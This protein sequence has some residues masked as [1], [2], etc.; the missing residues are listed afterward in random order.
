MKQSQYSNLVLDQTK[1]LFWA[2]DKNLYL[3]YANK[4]Y[5]N[6]MREVTGV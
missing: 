2:V 5:L 1:D 4:A 3:V 6:L